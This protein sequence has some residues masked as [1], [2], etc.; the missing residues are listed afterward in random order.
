MLAFDFP[1]D[2]GF[3]TGLIFDAKIAKEIGAAR[4]NF[5]IFS[6]GANRHL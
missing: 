3:T 4:F 5:L 1:K 2:V 6:L